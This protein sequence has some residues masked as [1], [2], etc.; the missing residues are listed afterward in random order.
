MT[1]RK[2]TA[3]GLI[4][5][6]V[7][8][9]MPSLADAR[10]GGGSS[11][12]SRGART[13]SAPPPTATA[14]KAAPMERSATPQP[15]PQR[16]AAAIPASQPG[17]FQNH[18]FMSGLM[19]G[20]LGAGLIGM[21]MGGG[22]GSGLGEASGVL[23]LLMQ[24][25][26]IGGLVYLALR[27]WRG[28]SQQAGGLN[29]GYA[30]AGNRSEPRLV[31]NDNRLTMAGGGGTAAPTSPL[32]VGESD[33]KEFE[34]LL[35]DVQTAYSAGEVNTLRRLATP[36]MSGY[37]AEQ[38]AAD[39][40]QGVENKIDAVKFEQGD[41]SEAWSEGDLD[42]ATVAMR[43]SMLD[44]TKRRDD[45]RIVAGSDRERVEATEFWTFLRNRGANW[46]LSA[47]QQTG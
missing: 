8:A 45:G 44:V 35:I 14:P 25:L 33:Y 40:S 17:F 4:L 7:L 31:D 23:G 13:F 16:P 10:A 15:A 42:Y 36:E 46:Q 43:F 18:P 9:L 47:V 3:L 6:G 28:K 22:F 1:F 32:N 38:L 24:L 37:L 11:A 26:L 5:V 19:G 27:L 41:L 39:A 20:M 29:P 12:G 2:W 34:S 30:Y 21:M